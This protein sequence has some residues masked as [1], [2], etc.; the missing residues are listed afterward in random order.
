[1]S[2]FAGSILLSVDMGEHEVKRLIHN[3]TKIIMNNLIY[4]KFVNMQRYPPHV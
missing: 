1:V 4:D 2:L 3:V